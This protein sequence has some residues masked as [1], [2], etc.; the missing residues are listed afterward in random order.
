MIGSPISRGAIASV[1][2]LGRAGFAA[3]AVVGA[4]RAAMAASVAMAVERTRVDRAVV[5]RFAMPCP[6]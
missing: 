2:G 1:A 5:N 4:I 3:D 6:D